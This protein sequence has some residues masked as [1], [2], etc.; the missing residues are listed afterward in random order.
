MAA[1]SDR[2][3]DRRVL[4]AD[5][6]TGEKTCQIKEPWRERELGHDRGRD[7]DAERDQEQLLASE[8][9]A[10]LPEEQRAKRTRPRHRSPLRCPPPTPPRVVTSIPSRTQTVPRPM[11]P[12]Q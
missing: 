8:P 1:R 12:R 3:A 6:R 2:R 11:T 10:Q 5:T 7:V 9:I 4:A